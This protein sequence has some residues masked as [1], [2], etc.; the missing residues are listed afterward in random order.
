MKRYF[1]YKDLQESSFKGRS[2]VS[3]V[4]KYLSESIITDANSV[5]I[6]LVEDAHTSLEPLRIN[7]LK[8][9]Q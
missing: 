2:S 7:R 3:S 1:T 9:S 8:A 4:I 6:E 5:V